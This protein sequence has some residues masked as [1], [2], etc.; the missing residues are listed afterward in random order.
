MIGIKIFK[1]GYMGRVSADVVRECEG[2][3]EQGGVKTGRL[4]GDRE[5]LSPIASSIKTNVKTGVHSRITMGP[6][7]SIQLS[8]WL[9]F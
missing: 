6:G 8:L 3:E 9:W 4:F 2:V 7:V 1:K 5:V